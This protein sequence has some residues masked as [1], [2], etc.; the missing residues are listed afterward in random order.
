MENL[1]SLL[2]DKLHGM[3]HE[4]LSNGLPGELGFTIPTG[5][6]WSKRDRI[7]AALGDR[8]Q[9]AIAEFALA[10]S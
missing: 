8:S 4:Q 6:G 7:N 5:E 10:L 1:Q 3:T 9:K 2:A